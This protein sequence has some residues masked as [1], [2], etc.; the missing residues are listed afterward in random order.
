MFINNRNGFT[1]FNFGNNS[2]NENRHN[3]GDKTVVSDTLGLFPSP[4]RRFPFS[5]RTGTVVA[6]IPLTDTKTYIKAELI[7]CPPCRN[8]VGK[9]LT[10]ELRLTSSK[11]GE[12]LA[13]GRYRS[14]KATPEDMYVVGLTDLA[15]KFR[16]PNAALRGPGVIIGEALVQIADRKYND[17][18]LKAGDVR[19]EDERISPL[20]LY[21]R[22]GFV[23]EEGQLSFEDMANFKSKNGDWP[24]GIGMHLPEDRASTQIVQRVR[25]NPVI[26]PEDFNK[27]L[28]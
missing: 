11:T 28:G 19:A 5:E 18:H 17:I 7:H 12:T 14:D 25:K 9:Q 23:P 15:P 10:G 6:K 21:L 26:K 20:P 13:A 8:V 27:Y 1:R 3:I 16:M 22:G 24:R 4:D 2:Q